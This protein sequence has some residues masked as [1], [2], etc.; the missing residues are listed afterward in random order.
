MKKKL[1]TTALLLAFGA[2][3][4]TGGTLA[5]FTDKTEDAVNTFVMGNVKIK[6][7]EEFTSGK[8]L[9]PGEANAIDK[10]IQIE[11]I[12]NNDAYVWY[13]YLVPQALDPA[14]EFVNKAGTPWVFNATIPGLDNGKVDGVVNETI[15]I[16]G[17]KYNRYVALYNDKLGATLSTDYGMEKV[18]LSSKV[19][20]KDGN[21]TYNGNPITGQFIDGSDNVN[22]IV[23]A[24]AIQADGLEHVDGTSSG[25]DVYDAYVLYNQQNTTP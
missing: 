25:V 10:K 6:L 14:L 3:A 22:I 13:E 16:H 9:L 2:V 12:G 24:Y 23:R 7:I 20:Y 4:I 8:T 11:N 19:D 21:Y 5:Y 18:Y 17:I 15:E 1:T